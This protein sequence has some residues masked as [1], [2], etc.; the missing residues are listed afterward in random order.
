MSQI[1]LPGSS[2]V[3]R[4]YIPSSPPPQAAENGIIPF[5]LLLE[6]KFRLMLEKTR[7][8]SVFNQAKKAV[9][10]RWLENPDGLV[11][12][13]TID[14]QNRD[15]NMRHSAL[16]WFQLDQGCIYRKAEQHGDT[17]LRP[18]YV[19]LD[20]N[21]LE[22]IEKEHRALQHYGKCNNQLTTSFQNSV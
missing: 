6:L 22:I 1:R 16:N 20:N 9:Y 7:N 15:R 2:P 13:N 3:G 17:L 11:E 5:P 21:A 19:A 10:R 8:R 4:V 18:R 14:A 12:G